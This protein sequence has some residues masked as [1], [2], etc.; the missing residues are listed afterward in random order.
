DLADLVRQAIDVCFPPRDLRRQLGVASHDRLID[1]SVVSVISE[2]S[3][4]DRELR[5]IS[6]QLGRDLYDLRLERVERLSVDRGWRG[7]SL[8]RLGGFWHP[9]YTTEASRCFRPRWSDPPFAPLVRLSYAPCP[10][11]SS[12]IRCGITSASTRSRSS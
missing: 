6:G 3:L 4:E 11:R 2:L 7:R 5:A 9:P 8:W 12:A 1:G 10:S